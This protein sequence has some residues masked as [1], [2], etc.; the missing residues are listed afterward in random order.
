MPTAEEWEVKWE[1]EVASHER[2][3][4][5]LRDQ[6]SE[7]LLALE[8]ILACHARGDATLVVALAHGDFVVAKARGP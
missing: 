5:V 7:L 1:Q 6:V 8:D 3:K 2:T 4:R